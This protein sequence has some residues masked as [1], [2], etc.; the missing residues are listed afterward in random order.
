VRRLIAEI[1][2][3]NGD[4]HYAIDA[5]D[6]F[7]EAGVW[8]VKGQLYTADTLASKT[9][10]SYGKGLTEPAT[11]REAFGKALSYDDWN[12]VNLRCDTL[13]VEFFGSVF[14]LDAV[15]AGVEQ[16]WRVFKI[17]SGDITYQ[18]LIEHTAFACRV[19]GATLILS[20]GASTLAEIERAEKWIRNVSDSLELIVLVCT[21]S[22][23]TRLED[24]HVDRITTLQELGYRV[25]YSDHTR[26][27]VAADY[28][29]RIGATMVEKHVTLTPGQGGDH[30]FAIGP[31]D[32]KRLV[33][34]D[35]ETSI[36]GD[37]V[38]AGDWTIQI[39]QT[40]F[41]A[42]NGARRSLHAA[43]DIPAGTQLGDGWIS[44]LRPGGGIEPWQTVTGRVVNRFVP[45][46]TRLDWSMLR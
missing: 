11:Q 9:A 34:G 3:A 38:V 10:K 7:A 13:G 42:R 27:I 45:A 44:A 46:G 16:G 4:L 21:L 31:A 12:V 33:D 32:V 22:Y 1:G 39:H 37:A 35:V 15:I 17:A 43:V 25:G 36:V 28:A 30:D 29:Y 24:A 19:S 20:T 14:D 26:G 2:S 5:V 6:A 8:A 18:Q 41:E 40:E 23:P